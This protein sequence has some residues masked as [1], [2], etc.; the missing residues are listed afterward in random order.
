M[1]GQDLINEVK[2]EMDT[3]SA[4]CVELRKRGENKAKT[5]REYRVA[6]AE[7][8]LTERTN[9][10]PV[11]IISDIC[12]GDRQ[13]AKLKYERDIADTLYDT[14]IEGINATKLR[15]KIMEN[16]IDREYRG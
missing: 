3:L 10:T 8:I 7:K 5:E 12:R 1:S 6:L 11:T 2:R 16:Q 13:I 15:L 4:A 9:G 14:C